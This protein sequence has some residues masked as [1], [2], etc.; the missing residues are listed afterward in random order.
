M[1]NFTVII[2]TPNGQPTEGTVQAVTVGNAIA[3]ARKMGHD[4]DEEATL[5]LEKDD[6]GRP[7]KA[8]ATVAAILLLAAWL[9]IEAGVGAVIL[10]TIAVERSRG[11][12]GVPILVLAFI[13]TVLGQAY[14]IWQRMNE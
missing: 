6:E 8:A 11:R 14:W 2:R 9:Y 1:R 4:V 5:K 7:G 12:R 3:V 10:S 13:V